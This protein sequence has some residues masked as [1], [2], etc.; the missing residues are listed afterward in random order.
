MS[1][2]RPASAVAEHRKR[3]KRDGFVRVEVKA[4]RGDVALIR[5]VAR[6]LAEAPDRRD[7]IAAALVD[8]LAIKSGAEFFQAVA[9]PGIAD[10]VDALFER[11]K[12]LPRKVRL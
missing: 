5:D 2:A 1:K 10:E 11:D 8:P 7:S 3:V 6:V 12:S 9:F 4:H